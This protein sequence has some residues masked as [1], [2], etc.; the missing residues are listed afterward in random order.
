M[1]PSI[2]LLVLAALAASAAAQAQT[3]T[4]LTL[5]AGVIRYAPD[6]Q[7]SG[8][9]GIGIP[10]GADATVGSANT[11]LFT[12]DYD[13]GR[14]VSVEL[15]LGVPPTIKATAS[16]SVAFLGEVMTAKNFAPT[17]LFNYHFG[18]AS[19]MVRP[20]IGIGINWTQFKDA[21]SPYGWDVSLN[22]STGVAAAIGVDIAFDKNWGM[23]ASYGRA[24][25]KSDLVAVGA[26]V[27]RTTID[28]RPSTY[29]IGGFYRF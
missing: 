6:A 26:T 17:L 7:T 28:F 3:F 25:V 14:N 2:R 20:Y 8:I 22:D 15:I 29:S 11:A 19:N 24:D 16:G 23:F 13:L 4:G 27:I 18:A 9:T 1:H 10:P 12:V 21:K 5:K